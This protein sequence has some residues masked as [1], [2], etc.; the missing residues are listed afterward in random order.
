VAFLPMYR[1]TTG[2]KRRFPKGLIAWSPLLPIYRFTTGGERA[3]SCGCL[4][5]PT[6]NNMP[7]IVT[8]RANHRTRANSC[9]IGANKGLI[10][11]LEFL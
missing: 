4:L 5:Y 9:S 7:G 1:Y 6:L 10:D 2:G 3:V 11:S 8:S